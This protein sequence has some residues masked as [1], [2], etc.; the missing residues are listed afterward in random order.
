MFLTI[1]F[2]WDI[3]ISSK[4]LYGQIDTS[5]ISH[6]FFIVTI[7][8]FFIWYL[9]CKNKSNHQISN[10]RHPLGTANKRNRESTEGLAK[11]RGW[12]QMGHLRLLQSYEACAP[13]GCFV[14]KDYLIHFLFHLLT[15]KSGKTVSLEDYN[16]KLIITIKQKSSDTIWI[17]C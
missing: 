3:I 13:D 14:S 8:F 5:Y 11:K 6:A 17:R 16:E 2:K 7:C 4:W 9:L 10:N 12:Y 15:I 1:C